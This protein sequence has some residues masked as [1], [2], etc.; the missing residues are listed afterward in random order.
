[1]SYIV[2]PSLRQT[3]QRS[4]WKLKKALGAVGGAAYGAFSTGKL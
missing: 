1:V 3:Y 2:F 4:H